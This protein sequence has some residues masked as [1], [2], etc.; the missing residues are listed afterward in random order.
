MLSVFSFDRVRL[1]EPDEID[2]ETDLKEIRPFAS[3]TDAI[4]YDF[5]NIGAFLYTDFF[6]GLKNNYVPK[7]C[8]N[9]GTYFLLPFGKYSDYCESSLADDPSKTCRDVSARK[10]YDEKC[11]VDPVWLAYNRAYKA[12]YA[13]CIKKKMTK[14]EFE[15]WGTYAIELRNKAEAGELELAEYERLIRI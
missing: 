6:K 2:I 14:G 8:R 15:K 3:D 5:E 7:K 10:K 1:F 4:R 12:H 9:C 11:R 13:R